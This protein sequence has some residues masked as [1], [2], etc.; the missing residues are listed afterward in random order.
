VVPLI[1]RKIRNTI[2]VKHDPGDVREGDPLG[3]VFS[4]M[5]SFCILNYQIRLE[6]SLHSYC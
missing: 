4:P 1:R 2:M 5:N 6:L 3:L